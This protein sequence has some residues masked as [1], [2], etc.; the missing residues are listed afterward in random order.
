MLHDALFIGWSH[1]DHVTHDSTLC[2]TTRTICCILENC[3]VGD[4]ESQGGIVVPVAL[5]PFMPAMYAEFIPFVNKAPIDEEKKAAAAS[6]A[7]K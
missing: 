4:L 7:K 6:T 5:R 2:A 3:Q 1:D